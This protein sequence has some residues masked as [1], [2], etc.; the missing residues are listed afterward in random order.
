MK[1][2]YLRQSGAAALIMV[3]AISVVA[4]T[5][6]V[7]MATNFARQ[8]ALQ[9]PI[10]QQ[11]YLE[12]LKAEGLAFYIKEATR[13][14]SDLQWTSVST[15]AD[16]QTAIN[17]TPKWGVH[18]AISNR[19]LGANGSVYR[20]I[21]FWLPSGTAEDALID[22][23]TFVSTGSIA[24][25]S[26]CA[27]GNTCEKRL[28]SVV[29]GEAVEYQNSINAN[30]QL[31]RLALKAQSYFKAHWL[32]DPEKNVSINYFRLPYGGTTPT[33][34]DI[35]NIPAYTA[36]SNTNLVSLLN[37]DAADIKNPWGLEVLVSN[38]QDSSYIT[39]PFSMSFKSQAPFGTTQ[40]VIQAIQPL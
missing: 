3:V 12:E 16:L 38:V 23:N 33:N 6:I 2:V 19:L 36:I 5:L 35:G 14:D 22:L 7:G 31:N 39:A 29:D 1:Q 13:L 24:P 30:D 15:E 8:E 4:F 9:L 11:A 10:K 32:Q 17:F 34:Q 28:I 25:F 40:F 18:S 37:L 21:V 26:T 27:Q 20:K